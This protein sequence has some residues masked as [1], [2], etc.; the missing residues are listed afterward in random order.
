[1]LE[2]FS[3]A[4]AVFLAALVGMAAE[5]KA[6]L[7]EHLERHMAKP[8]PQPRSGPQHAAGPRP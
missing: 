4:R 2:P 8:Q 3:L 6:R 7:V 5:E 1:M